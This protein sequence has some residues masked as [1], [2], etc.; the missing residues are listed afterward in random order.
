LNCDLKDKRQNACHEE[1]QAS[2]PRKLRWE[3]AGTHDRAFLRKKG[4]NYPYLRVPRFADIPRLEND[5]VR[6]RRKTRPLELGPQ[7]IQ[8]PLGHSMAISEL[9]K[10]GTLAT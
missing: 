7:Y 4:L 9:P 3:Q 8:P 2:L 10:A 6:L 5:A 1:F